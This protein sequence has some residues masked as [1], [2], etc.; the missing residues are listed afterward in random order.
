MDSRSSVEAAPVGA[1]VS[2]LLSAAASAQFALFLESVLG[3]VVWPAWGV[4]LL[5]FGW[6]ARLAS[7]PGRDRNLISS[8]A[9]LMI[10]PLIGLVIGVGMGSSPLASF[11]GAF[12]G[13]FA[14]GWGLAVPVAQWISG[15]APRRADGRPPALPLPG[16][17]FA[18]ALFFALPASRLA[19][20][21]AGMIAIV[22]LVLAA[23]L[24]SISGRSS[25]GGAVTSAPQMWT[26]WAGAALLVA[27]VAG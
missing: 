27:T 18:I 26:R 6:G 14:V 17:S 19:S 11:S 23:S 15:T 10:A 22:A 3:K 4:A 12:L 16:A 25:E 21:I 20:G 9:A 2:W 5:A 24:G 7:N 8:Q 1:F 13:I